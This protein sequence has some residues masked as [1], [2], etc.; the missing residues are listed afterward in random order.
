MSTLQIF[1][2]SQFGDIRV[3]IDDNG[4]PLFCLTDLCSALG[5]TNATSVS[6]R[7]DSEEV[8]K[9]DLGGRIGVTIF[10]TESGMYDVILRSDSPK[11]KPTRKWVT[12]EVLP[13]IRKNG[14]YMT[15]NTLEKAL[16]SPDFLI[17]LATNL[18]EEKQK[19]M[20]SEQK[21]QRLEYAN[22]SLRPK[23]LFADSVAMSTQNISINEMAK[24]LNQNG[25]D[26]GQNRLFAWLRDNKYLCTKGDMWNLPTQKAM[27]LDLFEVHKVWR[28]DSHGNEI[29]DG[30]GNTIIDTTTKVTGIGQ[31]YFVNKF[32]S[33]KT[34]QVNKVINFAEK[35][36]KQ[37]V[38]ASELYG[39]LNSKYD[40][41]MW[42]LRNIVV[43]RFYRENEHWVQVK[44]EQNE[45]DY[46]LT[47]EFAKKL[48]MDS[49]SN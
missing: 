3:A 8:T 18:K 41:W 31:I 14:A 37:T 2:N 23:A 36:G 26:I 34:E 10:V 46:I 45:Q 27:D 35:D 24:I 47:P 39:L 30:H 1:Q 9:L 13:T 6:Q 25:V 44:T 20:E 43:N 12:S 42:G 16:T 15:E 21:A 28:K 48:Y 4:E 17:Q 19:R 5:L 11:A 7:L 29:K 32:L 38:I 49:Q 22:Q 40:F 33:E